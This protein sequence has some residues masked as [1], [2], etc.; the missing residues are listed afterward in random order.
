MLQEVG[1]DG[2]NGDTMFGINNTWYER[3]LKKGTGNHV[4]AQPECSADQR[5]MLSKNGS[6]VRK[7][8]TG[9]TLAY[10]TLSWNY[11]NYL[12][13]GKYPCSNCSGGSLLVDGA[14][15]IGGLGPPVVSRYRALESR[16]MAQICE[17][18]AVERTDGLQH[19]LLNGMGYVPWENVWGIWNPLSEADGEALRRVMHLLKFLQPKLTGE[20][21]TFEPHLAVVDSTGSMVYCSRFSGVLLTCVNRDTQPHAALLRLPCSSVMATGAWWDAWRGKKLPA[22]RTEGKGEQRA[23][24]VLN[25]T[26]AARGYGAVWQPSAAEA[27]TPAFAAFMARRAAF[28]KVPLSA[29]STL[30]A[31]LQQTMVPAKKIKKTTDHATSTG[32]STGNT[33]RIALSAPYQFVVHGVQVEGAG[34]L[35]GPNARSQPDVQ[36]PWEDRPMRAHAPHGVAIAPFAID[37]FPV[38][39]ARYKRWLEGSGWRPSRASTQRNWLR[40]WATPEQRSSLSRT[41]AG[42]AAEQPVRWVSRADALA[43][44]AAQGGRLPHSWEWQ[45][46]LQ[47]VP[48]QNASDSRPYPWGESWKEGA[49]PARQTGTNMGE[50]SAYILYKDPC[51]GFLKRIPAVHPA[52]NPLYY[53]GE[54]SVVGAHPAGA[55][56]AGVQDLV[57]TIWQ[58]SDS[59]RPIWWLWWPLAYHCRVWML[60]HLV[61]HL[62][63]GSDACAVRT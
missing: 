48:S 58:M 38:T 5:G 12:P 52:V 4:A 40:H 2:F 29:L 24:C 14:S 9:D 16:H 44:C 54:P 22:T 50:S 28:A 17:R 33:T 60:R 47:Y 21:S 19:A 1:A 31:P 53:T 27:A 63:L 42:G 30:T 45:A 7:W 15:K 41:Y 11:W 43:F 34:G 18:W 32:A 36:F 57:G 46:A 23:A 25:V 37:T 59:V 49:V 3:S 61:C 51:C 10:N 6:R 55:S 62:L 8:A 26:L 56:A 35:A 20:H 39:N 13:P